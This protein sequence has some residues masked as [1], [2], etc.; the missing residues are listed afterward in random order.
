M[1]FVSRSLPL[2]LLIAGLFTADAFARAQSPSPATGTIECTVSTQHG[3]VRLPGVVVSIRDGSDGEVAEGTTDESGQIKIS[4]L[5]AASYRVH[6]ALDGFQDVDATVAVDA[7]RS[8]SVALDLAIAAHS[9]HVDVVASAPIS[10]AGTLA[11]ADTVS[12]R[13]AQLQMPGGGVQAALRLLPSA[14]QVASGTSIDGGRPDQ[15]GFQI[16]A[17]SLVDPVTDLPHLSLPAPAIESV[18]VLPNPYEVEFGRF[19]S[20]VVVVQTLHAGDRWKTRLDNLEPALRLKRFTLFDIRGVALAKPSVAT[21]GPLAGGRLFV[22]QT[23]QYHYETTDIPSRPEQELRTTNWFST[24]TRV[25]ATLTP[26]HSLLVTGGIDPSS[27][28]Q[29]TLGTFTPPGATADVSGG[30][31]HAMVSERFVA[32]GAALVESTLQVQNY[33]TKVHGQAT[34]TMDLLPET[35]SGSFFNRQHRDASTYQWIETL[36]GSRRGPGGVHAVKVGLDLSHGRYDGMSNSSPV[37]IS[38]PDDTTARR[39]DFVGPVTQTVASTD[40]AFFAQDRIQPARRWYLELGGRVD[41]NAIVEDWSAT[42][43][44]GVAVLL[45]ST[46]T[47]VIRGGYG[48]FYE[49]TPLVAGAFEQFQAEI[50]T[51]F[52]ADGLTPIGSSVL[53]RH[54]TAEDL[55]TGR[56]TT[57]DLTLDHRINRFWTIHLGVLDRE[58]SHQLIADPI[59][60]ARAGELLLS[61]TGI[62]SYHQADVGVHLT[63]GS[64][65]DANIT[66]TRSSARED[67]NAL[68]GFFDSVLVP[69]VGVNAYA[70]AAAD[71]P[72]RL[73]VRA[74]AMPNLRWLFVGTLDWRSGLPYSI[75]DEALEFVGPRNDRRF[76]TYARLDTGVDRRIAV[77]K[78]HPWVGLRVANALNSFLPTDVQA[79]VASPA[80]GT[81]YNSAYRE[82]RIHLRFGG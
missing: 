67:L 41:R 27:V 20:G 45:N 74:R 48:L 29:A 15:V 5:P 80:F 66:Y 3:E 73:L 2:I 51:R 42:P 59:A 50:D 72:N 22:E 30:I 47:D 62:S 1:R 8:V 60:T 16:Q 4:N 82:Y 10:E 68:V 53:Y 46:G 21:G 32:R 25:D 14:I 26:R 56:S 79:N 58:G 35:T 54:A 70:P 65:V 38:R 34:D 75:V 40:I 24:F 37:L 77:A 33:W 11:S 43:R 69:V 17:A 61:S 12:S 71:A 55:Q 63:G 64:R 9:E 36:S 23:A 57:W 13:E 44:V 49:R 7:G 81:F 52:A 28:H 19:S 31:L 76:P 18:A 39:L 78:V 6:A